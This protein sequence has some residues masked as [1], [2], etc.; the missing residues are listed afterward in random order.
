MSQLDERLTG[1]GTTG[2]LQE[3]RVRVRHRSSQAAVETR[4]G[5]LVRNSVLAGY[6][7]GITG[8][9][10]GHPFDS[11]K[12]WLQTNTRAAPVSDAPPQQPAQSSKAQSTRNVAASRNL[13]TASTSITISSD[14]TNASASKHRQPKG[15]LLQYITQARRLYAGITVPLLTV[16]LVQSINFAIYDATRRTLHSR[17]HPHAPAT[18]YLQNDSLQNVALAGVVAG[19]VLAV[20][21]QPMLQIKT[22]QQTRQLGIFEAMK[23]LPKSGARGFA[24]HFVSETFGRGI[25]FASYEYLKRRQGAD[26]GTIGLHQRMA[27]AA[28]SGIICWSFIFPFDALRCRMFAQ[29]TETTSL[30][31]STLELANLMYRQGGVQSF[32]RGFGVTVLRAGPVAAVVLPVYDRAL[33]SLSRW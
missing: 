16:G 24:P 14:V 17:E 27:C 29:Q 30:S 32:F 3:H 5:V 1:T 8:T 12:V 10:V 13:S 28:T 22:K 11:L 19:T 6:V 33:E 15:E 31:I 18:D 20:I 23:E 26:G 4:S 21:T 9:L 2:T 7:A 25:Y